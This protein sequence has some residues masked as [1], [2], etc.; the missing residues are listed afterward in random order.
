MRT[1]IRWAPSSDALHTIYQSLVG[2]PQQWPSP[3]ILEAPTTEEHRRRAADA[4]GRRV[5][6]NYLTAQWSASLTER[7]SR[8]G[9]P[10]DL[11]AG[12]AYAAEEWTRQ[13]S[14]A[15]HL[16]QPLPTATPLSVPDQLFAER[17]FGPCRWESVFEQA[18]ELYGFNLTL[19]VPIYDAVAAVSSD[20][21]V[22][23]LCMA[24]VDSLRELHSFGEL[25]LRWCREDLPARTTAHGQQRIPHLL[26]NYEQLCEGSPAILDELAGHEITVE[27]RPGNLGTLR[28][29]HL[30]AIF[31]DSLH[32]SIFPLFESL[33]W[34]GL[35]AWQQHYRHVPEDRNAPAVIAAAGISPR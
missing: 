28:P 1:P 4:W 27:T 9:A 18:L 16:H 30:A 11:L 17:H 33:G 20:P 19:S 8:L 12:S 15:V 5:Q 6:A 13:L 3:A 22:T 23:D 31:Y 35:D 29:T 32:Q 24:A 14:I 25:L 26:A 10:L 34:S 2:E 7:L 21:A